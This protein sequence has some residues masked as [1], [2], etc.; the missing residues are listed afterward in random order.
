MHGAIYAVSFP[1][2]H[3]IFILHFDRFK[4]KNSELKF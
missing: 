3:N 2:L 1:D 4:N